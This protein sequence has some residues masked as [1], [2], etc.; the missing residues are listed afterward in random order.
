MKDLIRS[1]IK[2]TAASSLTLL[3][4]YAINAQAQSAWTPPSSTP[5]AGNVAGP[6]TVSSTGQSKAGNLMLNTDGA[7][8]N[9]L[10]VAAGKVGIG[11]LTPTQALDVSG[12]IRMATQTA[13]ADAA[14]I[15]ATKGYVDGKVPNGVCPSGQFVTGI[16]NG[17]I[18]CAPSGGNQIVGG[19]DQATIF[20]SNC[21]G[22]AD[23]G[24]YANCP[25][26]STPHIMGGS[27]NDGAIFT[28]FYCTR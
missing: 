20:G 2:L 18:Q 26:G 9:G 11:T 23:G 21:W 5:P 25:T 13:T 1:T 28:Y 10:I 4:F 7:L 15:V 3:A 19:C 16:S 17:I 12:K 8:A 24:R 27:S 6:L 14:D 22:G